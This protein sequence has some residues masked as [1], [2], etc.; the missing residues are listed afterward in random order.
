MKPFVK[1]VLVSFTLFSVFVLSAPKLAE[2]NS[3]T[4]YVQQLFGVETVAQYIQLNKP[5]S[6]TIFG[7][8]MGAAITVLSQ[9]FA[10]SVK[11]RSIST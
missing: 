8:Y 6:E 2:F 3:A 5:E 4:P 11:I 1:T 9:N 7:N 10:L